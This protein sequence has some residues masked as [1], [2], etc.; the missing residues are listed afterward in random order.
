MINAAY[1]AGEQGMWKPGTPRITEAEVRERLDAGELLVVHRD[2]ALAGCVHVRSLDPATGELGLLSAAR[3][4]GGVGTELIER[5]EARAR[6][7]GHE[8]MRL[9]LLVPRTGTHPFKARLDAWYSALGY[10]AIGRV[11]FEDELPEPAGLLA[12]PCD[13]VNYEKA[14]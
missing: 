14:L 8:R 12:A 10:R 3:Q 4:G 7:R 1:A 6:E 2:G 11:A 5:A 13:L 9:Q